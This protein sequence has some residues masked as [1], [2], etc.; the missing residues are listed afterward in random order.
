MRR[1]STAELEG[2]RMRDSNHVTKLRLSGSDSLRSTGADGE[3]N[4]S[5]TGENRAAF[6]KGRPATSQNQA[7]DFNCMVVCWPESGQSGSRPGG[8][9]R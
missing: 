6:S 3:A 1:I 8:G 2:A 7:N 5:Q 4:A 9:H